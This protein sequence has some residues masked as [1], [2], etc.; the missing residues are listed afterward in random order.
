[1]VKWF[2]RTKHYVVRVHLDDTGPFTLAP[3]R[4]PAWEPVDP[5]SGQQPLPLTNC[6]EEY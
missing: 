4:S 5:I 1:M 3:F 2:F 6:L